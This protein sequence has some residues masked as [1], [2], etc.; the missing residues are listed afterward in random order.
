MMR[1]LVQCRLLAMLAFVAALAGFHPNIAA[2]QEYPDFYGTIVA[3]D[4]DLGIV[5][6]QL[7]KGNDILVNVEYLGNE[8]WHTGAFQ[9]DNVVILRTQRVGAD[10]MAISWEE[11]RNGREQFRG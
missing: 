5:V 7:E 1:L 8:P 3:A 2:A 11:A 6:I 9:L 10:Y 4:Q